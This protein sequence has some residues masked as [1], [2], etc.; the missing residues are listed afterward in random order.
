LRCR[1]PF[2]RNKIR[3]AIFAFGG[4]LSATFQQKL[5]LKGDQGTGMDDPQVNRYARPSNQQLQMGVPMRKFA[6]RFPMVIALSLMLGAASARASDSNSIER[7]AHDAYVTA[8]NSNDVDTLLGD[9][10]DDIVYQSPGDPEIVGKQAVRKWVA[11]YFGSFRTHW[12]KTSIGFVV[13]GDWAFERYT[14]KSTDPDK[15]TGAVS[16]D[17]G[18][19]INIFRRGTDGRW[20]VAIDGWSSDRPPGH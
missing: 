12:E 5:R 1:R 14:Y 11:T 8:I 10:T 13:N 19:G 15:K 20:R 9:L 16:T 7:A 4:I 3:L 17:V 6:G 2:E 18:K